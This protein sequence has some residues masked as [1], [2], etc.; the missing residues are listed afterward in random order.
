[1]A[2]SW[3]VIAVM[4]ARISST[5]GK[6]VRRGVSASCVL[7]RRVSA[8]EGEGGRTNRR[9]GRPPM[10]PVAE[11]SYKAEEEKGGQRGRTGEVERRE[12]GN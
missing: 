9:R 10:A 2:E 11:V 8:R 1:M 12:D 6:H 5:C 3:V 4:L 7:V